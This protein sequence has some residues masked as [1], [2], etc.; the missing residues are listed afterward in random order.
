MSDTGSLQAIY[1]R[2]SSRTPVKAVERV[3]AQAGT[4]L[5]G[6]HAG[7]G[8]RQ[9]TLLARE[10]WDAACAELGQAL[11]PGER[12]ANL[13]VEG[14][15]LGAAIGKQLTVGEVRIE[16]VGETKPCQLMD[17]VAEGLHDALRP[18]CRGGVYGRI[19]EGGPLEP[20]M[21]VRVVEA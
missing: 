13:V 10:G 18:E 17:D 1:L 9:V 15:D 8:K 14:V 20:G 21:P 2:P 12:R 5:V 16:V 3:E 6:D 11:D 19:L 7:A 4:G